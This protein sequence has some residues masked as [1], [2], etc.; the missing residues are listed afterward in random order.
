MRAEGA[1]PQ[2]RSRR[3]YAIDAAITKAMGDAGTV[4][5][6]RASFGHAE[7]A[8]EPPEAAVERRKASTAKAVQAREEKARAK[9]QEWEA[10]VAGRE[11][12][13]RKAKRVAA[14]WRKRVWY[15]DKAAAKKS[16]G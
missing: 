6:L 11:A 13:L 7:K 1:L 8:P 14:R 5:R 3:A 10:V 12:F 16:T 4:S 2:I 15:Y 9:L